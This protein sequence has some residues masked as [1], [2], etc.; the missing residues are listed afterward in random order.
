MDRILLKNKNH[1]KYGDNAVMDCS[2]P[3]PPPDP[4]PLAPKKEYQQ[5]IL[6]VDVEIA[7]ASLKKEESAGTDNIP[8]DLIQAG[9]ESP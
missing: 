6:R 4:P 7:I 2:R 5:P 3:R 1:E 8:A 9:D